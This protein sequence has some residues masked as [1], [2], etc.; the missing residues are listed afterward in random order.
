MSPEQIASNLRWPISQV[1]RYQRG[2]YAILDG[3]TELPSPSSFGKAA[4]KV[5]RL[6]R[7]DMPPEVE[8]YLSDLLDV[9]ESR[10]G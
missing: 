4:A 10:A 9:L 5:R 8:Q 2:V 1:H 3:N 7:Q 6:M